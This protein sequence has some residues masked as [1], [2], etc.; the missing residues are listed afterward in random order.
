MLDTG[1]KLFTYWQ[2]DDLCSTQVQFY[3][4]KDKNTGLVLKESEFGCIQYLDRAMN[5]SADTQFS[6][7][8]VSDLQEIIIVDDLY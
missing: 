7:A 3:Y 1:E 6:I 5:R 2:E 8:L 4:Y